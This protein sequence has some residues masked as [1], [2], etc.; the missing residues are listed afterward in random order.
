MSSALALYQ[1]LEALE[2]QGRSTA[3]GSTRDELVDDMDVIL[4]VADKIDLSSGVLYRA[5]WKR[6]VKQVFAIVRWSQQGAPRDI[7]Q[8]EETLFNWGN[9]HN[10][11]NHNVRRGRR[12]AAT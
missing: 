10:P 2:A 11:T 6:P 1:Y 9:K 12:K 4:Y 3:K 8:Q 7:P 5:F